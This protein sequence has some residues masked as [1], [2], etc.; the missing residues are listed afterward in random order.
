MRSVGDCLARLVA[1]GRNLG[2]GFFIALSAR[3]L[4]EEGGREVG[5]N[6]PMKYGD[7]EGGTSRYFRGGSR[8]TRAYDETNCDGRYYNDRTGWNYLMG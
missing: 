5:W 8:F 6:V 2:L 1:R 4:N 7:F 3:H